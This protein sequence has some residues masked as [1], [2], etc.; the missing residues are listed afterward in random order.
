MVIFDIESDGLLDDATTIHII[1]WTVDGVNFPTTR[2]PTVFIKF[3]KDQ[4]YAGGHNVICY[5]FPL[6]EK[7]HNFTYEGTMVDT[8]GLSWWSHPNRSR[9]SLE[10][11]GNEQG[12]HKVEVQAHQWK[13]GDMSLME[14]R[15]KMDVKINWLEWKR[16]E[17][18]LNELFS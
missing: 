4:P 11:I 15:V 18:L 2:D 6:L 10:A 3:L 8:L 12:N 13:E 1:C 17:R 9:H 7:L 16:Q 14:K 5:D